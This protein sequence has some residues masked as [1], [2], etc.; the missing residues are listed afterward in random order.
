MYND[1]FHAVRIL[2]SKTN[3]KSCRCCRGSIERALCAILI[4]MNRKG[5]TLIELLVV[6]FIILLLVAIAVITVEKSIDKANIARATANLRELE[7]VIMIARLSKKTVLSVITNST[8]SSANCVYTPSDLRNIPVSD[9]CPQSTK[10]VFKIITDATNGLI[11]ELTDQGGKFTDRA[12]ILWDPWGSPYYLDEN[13]GTY[14]GCADCGADPCR[15]DRITSAG[16]D[17]WPKTADDINLDIP[18]LKC[19][20]CTLACCGDYASTIGTPGQCCGASPYPSA[21]CP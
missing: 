8:W 4:L 13:E 5:Y 6:M 11:G 1:F 18:P 10:S 20:N 19:P 9:S 17:G 14:S 3:V 12:S 7:R 2:T 15:P 16:P 21:L